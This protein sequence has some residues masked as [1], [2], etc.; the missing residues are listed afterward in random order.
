M[1]AVAGDYVEDFTLQLAHTTNNPYTYEIFEADPTIGAP[2]T[3]EVIGRDY[4]V[5]KVTDI[6]PSELPEIADNAGTKIETEGG[7]EVIY[8]RVKKTD[9][10]PVT[11]NATVKT[12]NDTA[13]EVNTCSYSEN[14]SVTYD[15]QYLNMG[16]DG[17]A[18]NKFNDLTYSSYSHYDQRV[19]HLYWQC[20]NIPGSSGVSKNSF[21]REYI[22]R[23]YFNSAST[24]YKDT[25]VVYITA[26]GNN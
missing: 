5:Y 8:Y 15:G 6:L 11:L 10:K 9:N 14:G 16:N 26:I 2:K 18:T 20:T 25:D 17:K 21:Y 22:L 12:E 24:T 19:Q 23:V 3:G 4:V 7:E 13:L 1:F